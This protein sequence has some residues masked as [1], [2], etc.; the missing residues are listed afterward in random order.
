VKVKP[1]VFPSLV[2]VSTS[3]KSVF[4]RNEGI[5][6]DA[7][8]MRIDSYWSGKNCSSRLSKSFG[9]LEGREIEFIRKI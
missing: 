4:T 5:L 1:S 6:S 8:H 9:K 7:N 2:R 3:D